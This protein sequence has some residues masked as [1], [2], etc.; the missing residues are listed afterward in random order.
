MKGTRRYQEARTRRVAPPAANSDRRGRRDICKNVFRIPAK[1]APGRFTNTPGDKLGLHDHRAAVMLL[2]THADCQM[3][4]VLSE[5][6]GRTEL[7]AFSSYRRMR[8]AEN[9]DTKRGDDGKN[10]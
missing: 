6:E 8:G 4:L 7:Y 5:I 1:M 2:F 9:V 10:D 3:G